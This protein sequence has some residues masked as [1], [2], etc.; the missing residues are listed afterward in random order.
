MGLFNLFKN[1]NRNELSHEEK[2][3][4]QIL[5]NIVQGYKQGDFDYIPNGIEKLSLGLYYL[6]FK[7]T[8]KK[9]VRLESTANVFNILDDPKLL[10]YSGV[11]SAIQ[12][13]VQAFCKDPRVLRTN[14]SI[15]EYEATILTLLKY[16]A[17]QINKI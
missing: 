7:R 17:E 11:Y 4:A 2:E 13:S 9:V 6:S 1:K 12:E 3:A 15:Q 8:N 5:K 10:H 16:T 14:I